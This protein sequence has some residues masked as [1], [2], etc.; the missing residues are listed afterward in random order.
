MNGPRSAHT[1][2]LTRLRIDAAE[3]PSLHVVVLSGGRAESV[4]LGIEPVVVGTDEGCDLVVVERSVSRRHCSFTLTEEGIVLRDLGSKNGTLLGEVSIREARIPPETTIA[5]GALKLTVRVVGEPSVVPLSPSARFGEALG[6][7]I[8]MRAMFA[9]LTRAAQSDE[10]ILLRGESG[11]GKELLARAIHDQSARRD[12]PF[13]IFDCGAVAPMLVE[14]EL[15]GSVRG[16]YTG[17]NEDRSGVLEQAHGGTLFLDE[18]GDLPMDLQPKLLRAVETRQFRPVGSNRWRSFDARIV[19]ATHRD[20]RRAIADGSF[21][22]DLYYRI[23]VVEERVPP[24]RDRGED[25]ELLVERILAAHHPARTIR[26]LP[27]NTMAMLRAHS[28]PGNV[29]ELRNVL[30]RLTVFPELGADAFD[31]LE[32]TPGSPASGDDW[33]SYFALSL[34]DARDNIV[35]RFESAYVTAK[36]REHGGNVSKTAKAIGVSRQFLYRLIERHGLTQSASSND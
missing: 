16:A 29:R 36:L 8:A 35:E 11:T 21:R 31:Q 23:A 20:L 13:A 26:D 33:T 24:L 4:P 32:R 17:A 22:S 18:L 6:G 15:F 10:S 28:F 34:R 25:L 3:L 14:T 19:A 7:C 9:H 1:H 2:T 30:A 5:V 12:G 27:R